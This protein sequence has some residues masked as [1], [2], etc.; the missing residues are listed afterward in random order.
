MKYS[1]IGLCKRLI[2]EARPYW[3]HIVGFSGVSLLATPIALLKPVPLKIAV[4]S[5][6]DSQPLPGFLDVVLPAT[7]TG[8][9][10][11]V[12]I[13]A[14]VSF[15]AIT[16]LNQLQVLGSTMLRTYTGEKLVF[17]FRTLLFQVE[18]GDSTSVVVGAALL[19]MTAFAAS[20]GPALRASR[21]DPAAAL[22]SE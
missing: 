19:A 17:G 10:I 7:V 13:F 22:R 8:S 21:V 11:G 12:A 16:L 2:S 14:A 15:V 4:D 6:I 20:L 9:P 1:D 3:L 5:A 18:P